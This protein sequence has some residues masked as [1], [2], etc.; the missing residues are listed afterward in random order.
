[1]NWIEHPD[2]ETLN[3]AL[4]DRL[5]H[6]CRTT[7][8]K[9]GRARLALAGG[10]TPM[11]IYRNL[12][13]RPLDW[14]RISLLPGDERWVAHTDPACNLE[15]MRTAFGDCVADFQSLTPE[16]P[17][18]EPELGQARCALAALGN[19]FDACLLGMG[20]DGHFASLFPGARELARGLDP[21]NPDPLIVVHPQPLP[22]EAPYPRISLTLSA[23]LECPVLLMAMRG[24]VKR[25]VLTRAADGEA[26]ELPVAALL[27]HTGDQLEVHWS[28]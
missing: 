28:P 2:A 19:G 26:P 16:H 11:P 13:Q 1:M 8:A 24:P 27:K 22:A 6:T 10:S 7:L 3:A 12:A 18:P 5:E 15:A 20:G 17:G 4:A 9:R 14:P 25:E 21:S 23:I